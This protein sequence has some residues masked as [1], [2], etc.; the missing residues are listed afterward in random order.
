MYSM[1]V[2]ADKLYYHILNEEGTI[3]EYFV[4]KVTDKK[5]LELETYQYDSGKK[6]VVFY[7]G[8]KS[9]FEF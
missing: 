6:L 8:Y 4:L 2:S 1:K 7:K 5:V 9:E 3:D